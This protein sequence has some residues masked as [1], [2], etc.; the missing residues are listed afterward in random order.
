MS[1]T[2]FLRHQA[3][4]PETIEAMAKAFVSTRE[5]LGLS[6]RED[7]MTVSTQRVNERKQT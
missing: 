7:R 3:F 4:D 1:I 5:A 6:D 2:P